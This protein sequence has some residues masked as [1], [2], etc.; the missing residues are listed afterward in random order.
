MRRRS[1]CV[2]LLHR[3]G[4]TEELNID[5]RGFETTHVAPMIVDPIV[6]AGTYIEVCDGSFRLLHSDGD[7][8]P[9]PMLVLKAFKFRLYSL[10]TGVEYRLYKL[11]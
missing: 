6:T 11:G 4:V 5:L 10:L 9:L 2:I 3:N 1:H 7:S 8:R